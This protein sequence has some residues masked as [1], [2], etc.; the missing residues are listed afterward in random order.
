[1]SVVVACSS[2]KGNQDNN[3]ELALVKVN[4][5][6]LYKQELDEALPGG[7]NPTDSALAAEAY[8][9]MWIKDELMYEKAKENLSDGNRIDELVDNYRQSLTIFTYQEHLLK[10]R[11]SRQT[12]DSDLKAY[13]DKNPDK[14]D[15]Q[16]N[17]IK[18]LFLKV[19]LTSPRLDDLKKWY[20]S[21]S[22]KSIENI[23]KYSLENAVIYDLFY[24]RWVNFEDVMDNIP[25]IIPD[26]KQ[27]LQQNKK[28]EIQDSA[29]VYMLNIKEYLLVGDNA[30]YEYAK[31]QILDIIL[32]QKRENF[33][34]EIET[35]LYNEAL[36][37]NKITYYNKKP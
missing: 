10:Q 28:L 5:K 4:G 34:K 36:R 30:P 21:T 1:V 12:A 26:S 24:N 27:F 35:D 6:I 19:P 14:F 25:Y 17:I 16:S 18:G 11:L 20:Q 15:L 23:E 22:D 37:D 32:N 2:N 33:V 29:Y 8:I 3:D 9:K 7:L 13:F 31:G